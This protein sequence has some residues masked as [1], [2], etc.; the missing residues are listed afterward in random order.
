MSH[1]LSHS[2]GLHYPT[3]TEALGENGQDKGQNMKLSKR[4]R[5]ELTTELYDTIE[6]AQRRWPGFVALGKNVGS[7]NSWTVLLIHYLVI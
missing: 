3:A 2:S 6:S 5:R 1:F 7:I 4:A